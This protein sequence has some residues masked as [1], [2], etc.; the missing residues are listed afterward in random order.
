MKPIRYFLLLVAGIVFL[1]IPAFCYQTEYYLYTSIYSN[2][3]LPV[4][5]ILPS[6]QIVTTSFIYSTGIRPALGVLLEK[7]WLINCYNAPF[8]GNTYFI[9]YKINSD[10]SL[11][12]I[13]VSTSNYSGENEYYI[14]ITPNGQLILVGTSNYNRIWSI[15]TFGNIINANNIFT[16]YFSNPIR[17]Q[18]DITISANIGTGYMP[19]YH[20]D[21]NT[22]T[23]TSTQNISYSNIDKI[24]FT[25]D[26][27][28]AVG[29]G[30]NI[31][32]TF[33]AN[34]KEVAL[35]SISPTGTVSTTTV[36][37][38]LGLNPFDAVIS[39]DGSYLFLMGG[40]N[41]PI[42]TLKVNSIA[43]TIQD[44]GKRFY[45]PN[46]N[47]FFGVNPAGPTR[48]TPDGRML[49]YLYE[50]SLDN[51]NWLATAWINSDGSLTW[52][53]YNYPYDLTFDGGSDFMYDM[54]IVPNYTTSIPPELWGKLE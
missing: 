15:D 38:S 34:S 53:G 28:L 24:I 26:G 3:T 47:G 37:L 50:N 8:G 1:T 46:S 17:P 27:K 21:Y 45:Q 35:F 2:F 31:G 23:L 51:T 14:N 4:L 52:T 54:V 19:V 6:G 18:G 36:L 39:P 5:K 25:P 20:I 43:T 32:G 30:H 16:G 22:K 9:T 49:V 42:A 33:G 13:S 40:G 10:F 48:V 41:G 29:I 7:G 11:N 12:Q 44:T